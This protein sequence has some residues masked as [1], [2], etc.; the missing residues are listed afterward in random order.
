[1][2]RKLQAERHSTTSLRKLITAIKTMWVTDMPH[3]YFLSLAHSMPKRIR[4]VLANQGQ[5]TKY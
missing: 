2:K 4:D 3:S 1:M 5:M